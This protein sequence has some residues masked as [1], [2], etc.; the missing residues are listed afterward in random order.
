MLQIIIETFSNHDGNG[1]ENAPKQ[2]VLISNTMP[3]TC[4]LHFGTFLK[5]NEE[6]NGSAR[7]LYV[8]VHFFAVLSKTA[9]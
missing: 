3:C 4:V 6:C 5:F 8:L 2:Q 1:N 9:T 7:A